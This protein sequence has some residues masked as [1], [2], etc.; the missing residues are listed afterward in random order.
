MHDEEVYAERSLRAGARGYITKQ[1]LDDT[2][3]VANA[4]PRQILLLRNAADLCEALVPCGKRIRF[5]FSA[6]GLESGDRI[7]VV[8]PLATVRVADAA[9]RGLPCPPV[10]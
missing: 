6:L 9:R 5:S 7:R 8:N 10:P 2:V 1:Q 4:K 3:L